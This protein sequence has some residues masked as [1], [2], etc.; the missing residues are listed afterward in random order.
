MIKGV[1][2]DIVK[3]ERIKEALGAKVLTGSEE[4]KNQ[5]HFA[6]I[7]A[8]KEAIVKA[9]GCGIGEISF[10]DMEIVHDEKGAPKVLLSDKAKRYI[11]ALGA[12]TMHISISHEKE[13]AI[14]FAVME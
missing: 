13:F 9:M 12:D 8:A 5:E 1:G 7:W 6:G 3:V 14:A 10:K 2:T 4:Y 11:E